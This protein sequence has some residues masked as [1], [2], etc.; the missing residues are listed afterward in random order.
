VLRLDHDGPDSTVSIYLDP[1]F[2]GLGLGPRLLREGRR[3]LSNRR[4]A[5]QRLLA[6]IRPHNRA[7]AQAFTAAGFQ[8]RASDDLW[9]CETELAS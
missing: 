6:V 3:W 8:H 1:Q 4:P 5:T 9:I 2:T 7:S